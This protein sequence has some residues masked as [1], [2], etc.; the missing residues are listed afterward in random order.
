MNTPTQ[1]DED[2]RLERVLAG[3][4]EV[5]AEVFAEHRDRLWRMV[6]FRLDRRLQGRV[7]ADDILQEAFVDAVQR[8]EHFRTSQPMSLFVWLR[9]IVGQTLVDVHR[10]HLGAQMRDANREMSPQQQLSNGTSMSMSFHLLAHLTSPS[11]AAVRAELTGLVDEALTG[12]NEIDREVLALRHFEELTNKEVAEVLGIDRKAA[13]IRY[14]RA[15]A[16]LKDVLTH[17]PGFFDGDERQ[18]GPDA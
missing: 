12:M 5:F 3:D 15:L 11:Q 4:T 10:R 16:R 17:V 8:L 13:S 2:P 9:L 6:H 18:P 7:D 14:V 1:Q